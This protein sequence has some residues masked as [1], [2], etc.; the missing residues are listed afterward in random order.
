MARF[1]TLPAGQVVNTANIVYI[2]N[3][4][5][6]QRDTSGQIVAMTLK[7][8]ENAP[9]QHWYA[10]RVNMIDYHIWVFGQ[11]VTS[12]HSAQNVRNSITTQLTTV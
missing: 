3:V 6:V 7:E 11:N 5:K 12:E 4:M 2:T 10:F 8:I 9:E 1:I